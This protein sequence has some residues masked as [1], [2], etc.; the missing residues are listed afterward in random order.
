MV[1]HTTLLAAALSI[2]CIV[3]GLKIS[4]A[5]KL[6]GPEA[7]LPGVMIAVWIVGPLLLA[8]MV[9]FGLQLFGSR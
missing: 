6:E 1:L 5:K 9:N 2:S 3:L 4:R 8:L 7:S